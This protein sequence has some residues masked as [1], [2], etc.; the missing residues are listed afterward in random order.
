MSARFKQFSTYGDLMNLTYE[1][2]QNLTDTY[3][4]DK[5]KLEE[6]FVVIPLRPEFH[7]ALT[8]KKVTLVEFLHA[9]NDNYMPE[10]VKEA[11]QEAINATLKFQNLMNEKIYIAQVNNLNVNAEIRQLNAAYLAATDIPERKL[12]SVLLINK[13]NIAFEDHPVLIEIYKTLG[14]THYTTGTLRDIVYFNPE[15][16]DLNGLKNMLILNAPSLFQHNY[17][18]F[19]D[20][21]KEASVDA[22]PL[23]GC[24]SM[25]IHAR[26]S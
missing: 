4:A 13:K 2:L 17:P 11:H 6:K 24:M 1:E 3:K 21:I 16:H 22:N 26:K 18:D 19:W 15:H 8:K 25:V 9:M 5:A 10:D 12:K 7:D 23:T 20:W 14:L